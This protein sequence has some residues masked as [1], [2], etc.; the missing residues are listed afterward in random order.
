MSYQAPPVHYEPPP[1]AAAVL[2]PGPAGL[3]A[4]PPV[5]VP[6]V[7]YNFHHSQNYTSVPIYRPPSSYSPTAASPLNTTSNP[8]VGATASSTA[9][10]LPSP[11]NSIP[12]LNALLPLPTLEDSL[13]TFQNTISTLAHLCYNGQNIAAATGYKACPVQERDNEKKVTQEMTPAEHTAYTAWKNGTMSSL[14]PM[15]W[16]KDKAVPPTG[17]TSN[18]AKSLKVAKKRAEALNRLYETTR[19]DAS[20]AVFWAQKYTQLLPLVK[21]VARIVGAEVAATGGN[22]NLNA[23]EWAELQ[24][25]GKIISIGSQYMQKQVKH[26]TAKKFINGNLQVLIARRQQL[27]NKVSGPIP[28]KRKAGTD[29]GSEQA[30]KKPR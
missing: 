16:D 30:A 15:D 8:L 5:T 21:A 24:T 17:D 13:E 3:P 10:T 23:E 29:A 12:S 22:E 18:S 2:P 9:H 7:D 11:P 6:P 25:L 27:Q 1:Q 20:H 28:A 19:A 4:R 26:S 14:P